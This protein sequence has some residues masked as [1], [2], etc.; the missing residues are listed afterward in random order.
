VV[1]SGSRWLR[2]L[3][4]YVN[5]PTLWPEFKHRFR[6]HICQCKCEINR[7]HS[8]RLRKWNW[9]LA[10]LVDNRLTCAERV[11]T[12]EAALAAYVRRCCMEEDFALR[13]MM[14][15]FMV[16][17]ASMMSSTAQLVLLSIY[18]SVNL[19]TALAECQHARN[20]YL[21]NSKNAWHTFAANATNA[22]GKAMLGATQQNTKGGKGH[23]MVTAAGASMNYKA[24]A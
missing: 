1:R 12:A 24:K 7:R 5:D 2:V 9:R 6:R 13:I 8:A 21:L 23:T 4:E 22:D 16:D 19:T 17:V 20:H 14:F 15:K 18:W 3:E 10:R 11:A